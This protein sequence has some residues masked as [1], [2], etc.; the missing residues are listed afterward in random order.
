MQ[1]HHVRHSLSSRKNR[2]RYNDISFS[3]ITGQF[4]NLLTYGT[5]GLLL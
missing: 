4:T 1:L 3:K 5:A 2:T